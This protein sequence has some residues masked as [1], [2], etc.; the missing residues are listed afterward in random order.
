MQ[1][2]LGSCSNRSVRVSVHHDVG[3]FISSKPSIENGFV[4]VHAYADSLLAS[5]PTPLVPFVSPS[6]EDLATFRSAA[7]PTVWLKLKRC[8][9]AVV[10]AAAVNTATAAAAGKDGVFAFKRDKATELGSVWLAAAVSVRR[11]N[12]S[13]VMVQC[14]SG[15]T[16]YTLPPPYGGNVYLKVLSRKALI[17]AAAL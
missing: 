12:S 9:D 16:P 15:S 8:G 11:L 7:L 1:L 14:P 10:S 2:Q 5:V 13:V 6:A 3:A 4:D 17:S